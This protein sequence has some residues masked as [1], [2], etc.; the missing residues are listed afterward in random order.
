MCFTFCV[1]RYVLESYLFTVC[2]LD[3]R[4]LSVHVEV[5]KEQAVDKSGLPKAGLAHHHE[6]EV[7]SSLHRL[8]VHLLR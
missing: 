7:E 8:T 2:T 5:S 3:F 6:C 1:T 4:D